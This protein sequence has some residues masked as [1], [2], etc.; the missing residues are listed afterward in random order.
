MYQY[1]FLCLYTQRIYFQRNTERKKKTGRRG[2]EGDFYVVYAQK[3]NAK[4]KATTLELAL[5]FC[6]TLYSSICFD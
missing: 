5:L 2:G 3:D 4:K 6:T 1:I